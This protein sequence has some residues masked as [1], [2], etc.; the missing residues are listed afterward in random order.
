MK[1][2]IT[3]VCATA[4]IALAGCDSSSTPPPRVD[5][6]PPPPP[7]SATILVLQAS[8]D[9][10]ILN[11]SFDADVKP[12]AGSPLLDMDYKS[13]TPSFTLVTGP[14]ENP[15]G[16]YEFQVDADLPDG[17]TATVI[18]PLDMTFVAN[19]VYTIVTAGNYAGIA[20]VVFEQTLAKTGASA[21]LRIMHVAPL[22]GPVD[23]YVTAPDADLTLEAPL[24]PIDFGEA[25]D[26]LEFA[27]GDYQLRITTAGD[28]ADVLFDGGTTTLSDLDD[29][30]V[31]DVR[32]VIIFRFP[33]RLT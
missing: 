25:L 22:Q 7:P 33:G 21:R 4:I 3:V 11:V 30:I 31:A 23:V 9:A 19:T 28:S 32:L 10:P 24:G 1:N 20:P 29:A 8:P 26:P 14:A 6:P 16:V 17:T 13:G 18:G 12:P 15:D 5:T 2:L 27:P